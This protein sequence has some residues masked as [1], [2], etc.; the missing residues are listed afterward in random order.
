M[1]SSNRMCHNP[2]TSRMLINLSSNLVCTIDSNGVEFAL[3]KPRK[4][5]NTTQK[6]QDMT[7]AMQF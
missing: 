4:N 1:A 5:Y 3:K 2:W 6:W 7:W